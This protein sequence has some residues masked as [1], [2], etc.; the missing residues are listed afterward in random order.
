MLGIL[1][2]SVPVTHLVTYFLMAGVDKLLGLSNESTRQDLWA[3]TL[4]GIIE[5]ILYPV[6]LIS[7]HPEF[8]GVWLAVKVAG[9]WV[10]WGTGVPSER[11]FR[12]LGSPNKGRRRFNKFL[13]GNGIRILL[14]GLTYAV[15]VIT[16]FSP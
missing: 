7:E 4:V 8:I 5:S 3:P 6:V 14:A 9:Q 12:S 13:V 16:T 1:L 15:I 11:R 2:F 10:G